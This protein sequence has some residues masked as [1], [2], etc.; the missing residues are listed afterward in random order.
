MP[1]AEETSAVV[2]AEVADV[3]RQVAVEPEL[4]R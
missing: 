4:G 1:A 3:G 2:V